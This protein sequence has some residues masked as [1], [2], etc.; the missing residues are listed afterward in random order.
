MDVMQTRHEKDRENQTVS[1]LLSSENKLKVLS[2]DKK[3]CMTR[4]W[5]NGEKNIYHLFNP[6]NTVGRQSPFVYI[7]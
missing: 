5:D 6:L 3:K 7:T 1:R 2:E 4:Q